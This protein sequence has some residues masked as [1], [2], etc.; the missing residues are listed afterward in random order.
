MNTTRNLLKLRGMGHGS[1]NASADCADYT[2]YETRAESMKHELP[3]ALPNP[4]F[5]H[6][7]VCLICGYGVAHIPGRA[8]FD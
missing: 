2:D 5:T 4:Y 7:L 6:S 1:S 3:A 8:Y